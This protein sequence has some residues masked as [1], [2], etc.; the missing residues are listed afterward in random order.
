MRMKASK[1]TNY[2][3]FTRRTDVLLSGYVCMHMCVYVC[4]CVRTRVW[5]NVVCVCALACVCSV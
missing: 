2:L 1:I 4:M 5:V 3:T